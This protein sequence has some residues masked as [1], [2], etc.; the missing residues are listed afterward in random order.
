M[1]MGYILARSAHV[2]P[3]I[4]MSTA[5]IGQPTTPKTVTGHGRIFTVVAVGQD[6]G[7]SRDGARF[8][9]GAAILLMKAC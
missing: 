4:A 3:K 9:R 2:F 5:F 8:M 1:K 6:H 7:G